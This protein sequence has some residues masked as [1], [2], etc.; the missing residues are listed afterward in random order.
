MLFR[1]YAERVAITVHN[2]ESGEY[3]AT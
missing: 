3:A 2:L 1:V